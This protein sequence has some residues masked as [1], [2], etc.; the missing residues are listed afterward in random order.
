MNIYQE[1]L[2]NSQ[3]PQTIPKSTT[4][5]MVK[6]NAA[7]QC[8]TTKSHQLLIHATTWVS[9]RN[10]MLSER[11]Q[12]E[13]TMCCVIPFLWNTF[14]KIKLYVEKGDRWLSGAGV[15]ERTGCKTA[16][17]S[18]RTDQSVLDRTVLTISHLYTIFFKKS[19]CTPRAVSFMLY[20]WHLNL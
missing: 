13:K 6:Q 4:W 20:K 15:G 9:L 2:L 10:I 17:E 19:N 16:G 3:K 12:T 8:Y 7:Y 5:R 11:S 1:I 14:K 18:F